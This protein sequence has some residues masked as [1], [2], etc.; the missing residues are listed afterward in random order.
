MADAGVQMWG[1]A[2]SGCV[3]ASQTVRRF[4]MKRAALLLAIAAFG[5]L[6]GCTGY[7]R[8]TDPESGKTYYTTSWDA[9]RYTYSGAARF[10]DAR[11][12]KEVTLQSSE[13]EQLTK[14]EWQRMVDVGPRN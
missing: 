9:G 5:L 11:S 13:V 14:E 4:T 1:T 6:S 10:I 2:A 12:G 3:A 8:V 7:Y